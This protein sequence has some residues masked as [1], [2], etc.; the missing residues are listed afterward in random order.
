MKTLTLLGVLFLSGCT[1]TPIDTTTETLD[2]L[3]TAIHKAR[4]NYQERMDRVA[5]EWTCSGMSWSSLLQLT[6]GSLELINVVMA[7]CQEKTFP[8]VKIP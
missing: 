4:V 2:G 7:A 1:I 6:G 5:L 8:E 3:E